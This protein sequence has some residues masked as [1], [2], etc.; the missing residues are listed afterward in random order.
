MQK[1]TFVVAASENNV[2]GN[3]GKLPWSLP[4]DLKF[5]KNTTWGMPVVMGRKTFESFKKM[6]GGRFN[7]VITRQ[8]DYKVEGAAVVADLD[9]AIKKA[10]EADTTEIFIIGGG[11]IFKDAMGIVD[12]IHLTRVHA[13]FEGDAFFPEIDPA[14]WKLVSNE[15]NQPDEKHQYAYSFQTWERQSK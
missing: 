7:V 14:Q 1:L 4:N 15:D 11:E 3:K 6:L 9:A 12:R 2:I 10:A 8:P 5:F 13:E